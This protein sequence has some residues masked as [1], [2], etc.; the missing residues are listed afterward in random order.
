MENDKIDYGKL[1]TL[2]VN[3][4]KILS[5]YLNK[6]K[7]VETLF[8]T[9]RKIHYSYLYILKPITKQKHLHLLQMSTFY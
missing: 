8:K 5:Y 3:G 6:K 9:E 1:I 7:V 4:A 2:E